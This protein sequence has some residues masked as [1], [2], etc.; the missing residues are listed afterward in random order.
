VGPRVSPPPS[1][2]LPQRDRASSPAMFCPSPAACINSDECHSRQ[3]GV[4]AHIPTAVE[5]CKSARGSSL[6]DRFAALS[7]DRI[8]FLPKRAI[9]CAGT[10]TAC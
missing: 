5:G 8:P 2:F 3:G 1:P 6:S 7:G 9:V 10:L 4:P